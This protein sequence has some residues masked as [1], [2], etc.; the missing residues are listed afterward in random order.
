MTPG[1]VRAP[2]A[3]P[4]LQAQPLGER[5]GQAPGTALITLAE[6]QSTA[7]LDLTDFKRDL[8]ELT[9]RLGHAQDCL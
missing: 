4:L 5:E 2:F 8:S 9:D 1:G 3:D 6:D 7:L